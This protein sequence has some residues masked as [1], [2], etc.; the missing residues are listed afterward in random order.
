[1]CIERFW[2]DLTK[3]NMQQKLLSLEIVP[4]RAIAS[5][6]ILPQNICDGKTKQN[7]F[8]RLTLDSMWG[9]I[10]FHNCFVIANGEKK[11]YKLIIHFPA[12]QV[13]KINLHS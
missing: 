2:N 1:V 11:D 10:S 3:P 5:I 9:K 8:H 13:S 7:L 6:F 12:E 4:L